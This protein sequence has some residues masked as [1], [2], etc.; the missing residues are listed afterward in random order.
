MVTQSGNGHA[1]WEWSC[2]AGMVMRGDFL[3]LV[4]I[5]HACEVG[6]VM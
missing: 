5:G 4:S 3:G 6:M 2:K 1:K